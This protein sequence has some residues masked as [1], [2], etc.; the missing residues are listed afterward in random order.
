MTISE[1]I[2]K[3]EKVQE[4]VGRKKEIVVVDPYDQGKLYIK[5]V[6]FVHETGKV[7]IFVDF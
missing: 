2:K 6:A 7:M 3:L 5:T 4:E 1:L